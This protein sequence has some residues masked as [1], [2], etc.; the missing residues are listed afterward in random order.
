MNEWFHW[1]GL[2]VGFGLITSVWIIEYRISIESNLDN[3]EK[4]QLQDQLWRV[5]PVVMIASLIGARAWHVF[6]DIH[7]YVENWTQIIAINQGGISIFGAVLGAVLALVFLVR[8]GWIAQ[9]WRWWLDLLP[10]GVPLGQ[11]V[12][13]LGNYV[14][15]ELYGYPTELPWGIKIDPTYRLPAFID[16]VYFHPL[17]AYEILV[18][19]L[20]SIV[21][22]ILQ[23]KKK[24]QLGS[25]DI[26]FS[27]IVFYASWR[28]AIDFLRPGRSLSV[29]PGLGDNQLVLSGLLVCVLAFKYYQIKER[30]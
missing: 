7:I 11:M 2:L 14:N 30:A 16:S 13:R 4:E 21:L 29:V 15:Q 25:G 26:F 24:L 1:Y 20:Y 27:Y 22:W 6:T 8:W 23:W 17:F 12:G 9:S 5:L 28:I 19:A 18:L 3:D 10:F